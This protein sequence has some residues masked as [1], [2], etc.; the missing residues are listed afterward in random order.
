MRRQRDEKQNQDAGQGCNLIL[1]RE[2]LAF[3]SEFR[4]YA[5]K[6]GECPDPPEGGT[7]NR[8][9][10]RVRPPAGKRFEG[11]GLPDFRFEIRCKCLE[12]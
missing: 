11:F 4:V 2:K 9:S 1:S 6:G 3:R 5:V 10:A 8:D 7:P 12:L